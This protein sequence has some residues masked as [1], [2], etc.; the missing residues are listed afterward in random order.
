V[1]IA[2][3]GDINIEYYVEG[4]GPPLLMLIGVGG[5]AGSWGEPFLERLR[6]HFRIFP[7][8]VWGRRTSR[9]GR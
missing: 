8:A 1:P 6:P 9:R 3:V 5:H 2:K 4:E 7:I